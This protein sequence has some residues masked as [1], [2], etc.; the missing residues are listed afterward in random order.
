MF[1]EVIF[2]MI[3][4]IYFG[5][6]FA[7]F[8]KGVVNHG[9]NSNKVMNTTYYDKKTKKFYKFIPEIRIHPFLC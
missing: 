4:G 1:I 5:K 7:I 2:G 6:L 3:L 9:P 8:S